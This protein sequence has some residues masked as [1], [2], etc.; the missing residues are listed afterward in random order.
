MAVMKRS[1]HSYFLQAYDR[2]GLLPS[3][4]QLLLALDN[5]APLSHKDLAQ[6]MHLTPGAITQLLDGLDGAGYIVRRHDEED[7]R[8][9]YLSLSR[10]GRHK[11]AAIKKVHAEVLAGAL[12]SLDD[13]ELEHYRAIQQKIIFRLQARQTK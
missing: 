6:Q 1:L 7:R 13:S 4:A 9:A 12:S 8:I 10:A 2:L 5:R 3:Q 11:I